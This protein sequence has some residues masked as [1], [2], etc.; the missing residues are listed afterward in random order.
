MKAMPAAELAA[1]CLDGLLTPREVFAA[2]AAAV[3]REGAALVAAA[4][5]T[6][7]VVSLERHLMAGLDMEPVFFGSTP[8]VEP[9][10]PGPSRSDLL[11]LAQVLRERIDGGAATSPS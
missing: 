4:V 1:W 6:E 7:L 11:A 8:R 2:F 3:P 10:S 9:R 5:P